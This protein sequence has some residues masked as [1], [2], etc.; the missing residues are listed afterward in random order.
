VIDAAYDIAYGAVDGFFTVVDAVYTNAKNRAQKAQERATEGYM[1]PQAKAY[2]LADY[3][4]NNGN[5]ARAEYYRKQAD[6][7]IVDVRAVNEAWDGISP[8]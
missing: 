8:E 2:A 7:N 5:E 1:T 3:Y 6:A 4:M